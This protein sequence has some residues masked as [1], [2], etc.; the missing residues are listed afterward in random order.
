MPS[1]GRVRSCDRNSNAGFALHSRYV[2]QV[3]ESDVSAKKAS[4]ETFCRRIDRSTGN[5]GST[6]GDA[7]AHD[8]SGSRAAIAATIVAA[9]P[10]HLRPRGLNALHDPNHIHAL[11]LHGWRPAG[12]PA[13]GDLARVDDAGVSAAGYRFGE[14][15]G[16]WSVNKHTLRIVSKDAGGQPARKGEER[17]NYSL[18]GRVLSLSGCRLAGRYVRAG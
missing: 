10:S 3:G 18:N 2:K 6:G 16:S 8:P 5:C 11:R 12:S 1:P 15:F 14:E 7:R 17:C 13:D 9:A 4:R